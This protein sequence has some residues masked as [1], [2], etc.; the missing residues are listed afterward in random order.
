MEHRLHRRTPRAYAIVNPASAGGA[1]G[2]QWSAI[3]CLLDG[4]I[5]KFDFE[6]TRERS[7]ATALARQ[8]IA[9]GYPLIV[10]VGG[11]GTINEVANGFFSGQCRVGPDAALGIVP[12]GTG[13]DLNR[14]IDLGVSV[15]NA[16]DRLASGCSLEIDI[17]HVHCVGKSGAAEDRVFVNVGSFGC[18]ALA[19]ERLG[20]RSK[21]LG[22]RYSYIV[23]A[24][25]A[26]ATY[27]D[28]RV[29]VSVDGAAAQDLSVT[30]F[31][32]CNGAYFGGG[33]R[34]APFAR[35]NDGYFDVTVWRGFGLGDLLMKRR[36]LYDGTHLRQPGTRA[37]RAERLHA[38]AN[39]H[40]LLELD[41]EHVGRLPAS[42]RILPRALRLKA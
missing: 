33:I 30:N 16:C 4:A 26:L 38:S 1:T 10:A 9:A 19:V 40:V 35:L 25:A 28:Q 29:N 12:A 22:G 37:F 14:S 32:I 20:S 5:G 7:H 3:A 8:A 27:R 36:A 18:A 42:F 13:S 21:R 17:G 6:F 34:V 23:T 31:A 15:K 11:D 2:R 41:G 24:A 39:D